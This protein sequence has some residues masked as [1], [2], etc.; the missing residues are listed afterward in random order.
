MIEGITGT[1]EVGKVYHGEVVNIKEFGVFVEILPGV[2]GMCHVSELDV[3]YVKNPAE[4][5][6]V[7]DKMDVKLISVDDLGRLKLSRKAL[8]VPAGEGAPEGAPAGGEGGGGGERRGGGGGDRRGGGGDR[9][10][11]GGGRDRG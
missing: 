1:P 8:L 2:D 6:K 7:G 4:F 3:S 11:R 9:G 5:C 10:R